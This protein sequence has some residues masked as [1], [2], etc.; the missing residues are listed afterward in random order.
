MKKAKNALF[1]GAIIALELATLIMEI[2]TLV[3]GH[4]THL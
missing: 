1:Y 2:I 4:V 3:Q